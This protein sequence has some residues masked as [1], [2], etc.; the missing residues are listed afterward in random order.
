MVSDTPPRLT[1]TRLYGTRIV[2][3]LHFGG[4]ASPVYDKRARNK[5]RRLRRNTDYASTIVDSIITCLR[6]WNYWNYW[7]RARSFK[8]ILWPVEYV[9]TTAALCAHGGPYTTDVPHTQR[10]PNVRANNAERKK[11]VVVR[12]SCRSRVRRIGIALKDPQTLQTYTRSCTRTRGCLLHGRT[13]TNDVRSTQ[14]NV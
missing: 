8:G 13:L 5:V 3:N 12:L 1:C 11:P 4:D 2:L 10:V 9:S 14:Q 6:L 7:T